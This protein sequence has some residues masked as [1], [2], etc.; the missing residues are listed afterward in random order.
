MSV[1][2]RVGSDPTTYHQIA[3]SATTGPVEGPISKEGTELVDLAAP[4]RQV[5][6]GLEIAGLDSS[7]ILV[8][9]RL[10]PYENRVQLQEPCSVLSDPIHGERRLPKCMVFLIRWTSSASA[11]GAFVRVELDVESGNDRTR[12]VPD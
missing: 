8:T 1:P 11:K 10:P 12:A 6:S 2:T 5:R 4:V 3:T 7:A 9:E